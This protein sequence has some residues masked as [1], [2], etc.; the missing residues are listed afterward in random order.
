MSGNISIQ[1]LRSQ[2]NDPFAPGGVEF[3]LSFVTAEGAVREIKRAIKG[4]KDKYKSSRG[5]GPAANK[6][7]YSLK[8]NYILLVRDLDV[9]NDP[10]S[11]DEGIRSVRLDRILTFNGKRVQY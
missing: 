8:D 11:K 10:R 5:T 4:T 7:I 6:G 3:S 2:V 1:E 9:A